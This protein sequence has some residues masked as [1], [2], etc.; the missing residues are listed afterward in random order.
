MTTGMHRASMSMEP[1]TACSASTEWGICLVSSSSSMLSLLSGL[2]VQT[3]YC[4][5]ATVTVRVPVIS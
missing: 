1:N 3:D 5:S 2:C 4:S